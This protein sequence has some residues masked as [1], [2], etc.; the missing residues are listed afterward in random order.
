MAA[1]VVVH[2]GAEVGVGGG[3]LRRG[4][5]EDLGDL[6]HL[7]VVGLARRRR[8]ERPDE[9][10]VA[11]QR[12]VGERGVHPHEVGRV[13]GLVG[14]PDDEGVDPLMRRPTPPASSSEPYTTAYMASRVPSRRLKGLPLKSLWSSTPWATASW[15]SCSIRAR[16]APNMIAGSR[17]T[18]RITE[19]LGKCVGH[20]RS[21]HTIVWPA[22]TLSASPVTPRASSDRSQQSDAAISSALWRRPSGISRSM[23]AW[24]PLLAAEHHLHHPVRVDEVGV[25]RAGADGVHADLRPGPAREPS[26]G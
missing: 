10:L 4:A 24:R 21:S 22:L 12:G 19:P 5:A 7:L 26:S 2:V 20:G 16:P 17:L 6:G 23:N 25:D 15:A 3:L 18:R 9:L 8:A 11:A 14:G 13:V 1:T